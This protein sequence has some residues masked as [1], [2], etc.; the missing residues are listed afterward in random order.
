MPP[1]SPMLAATQIVGD[2]GASEWMPLSGGDSCFA[3]GAVDTFNISGVDVND[4]SH[5][6]VR[7]VSVES[8]GRP[9]WVPGTDTLLSQPGYMTP[10]NARLK[11]PPPPLIRVQSG[12]TDDQLHSGWNLQRIEILH[13]VRA[14]P[15][16]LFPPAPPRRVHG[17]GPSASCILLVITLHVRCTPQGTGWK[18]VFYCN[19]WVTKTA[20]TVLL[21]EADTWLVGQRTGGADGCVCRGTQTPDEH[22]SSGTS[23]WPRH[24]P[25]PS[26]FQPKAPFL[27]CFALPLLLL[28]QAKSKYSLD[29]HTSDVKGAEFEGLAYVT[30]SG[31]WGTSKEVGAGDLREGMRAN[32][33]LPRHIGLSH[34]GLCITKR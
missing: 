18:S 16:Y 4:L 6:A 22:E 14:C 8:V 17:C 7:L 31:W 2:L 19:D 5:L 9:G 12:L 32:L 10:L 15:L 1:P 28:R 20:P 11:A 30:L 25:H 21:N 3:R 24:R 27:T 23:R 26:F 34:V 33:P 29:I 13:Q